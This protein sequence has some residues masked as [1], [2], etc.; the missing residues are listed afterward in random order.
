MKYFTAI[1][2]CF[3]LFA[4]ASQ[5]DGMKLQAKSASPKVGFQA[6][7]AAKPATCA[8]GF[9]PIGIKLQQ[10][11][12]K[13]WYEYQCVSEQSINR[14]CNADTQV[15]DVN[16]KIVSLPSDGKSKKSKIQLSYKCFNYVPVE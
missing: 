4:S 8:Q 11:E 14:I 15:T 16:D 13:K 10:H 12:G 7:G 6:A 3:L 9:T 1:T 5:A 2:M